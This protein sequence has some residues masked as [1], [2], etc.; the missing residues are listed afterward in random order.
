M[1]LNTDEMDIEFITPKS[2]WVFDS[3]GNRALIQAPL[4][5]RWMVDG[6]LNVKG[7]YGFTSRA[8]I[9][10]KYVR[11]I[12]QFELG[13]D[14]YGHPVWKVDRIELSM[15][16]FDLLV[17][18]KK[19][20]DGVLGQV[21]KITN[22]I[23]GNA[24]NLFGMGFTNRIFNNLSNLYFGGMEYPFSMKLMENT[25]EFKIDMRMTKAVDI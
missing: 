14:M 12:F 18:N 4:L 10:V 21:I 8:A 13:V 2:G 1:L 15:E 6:D 3:P 11:F 24:M 22:V 19:Y 20:W 9:E 17:A 16:D 5:K 23:T 7:G 25:S